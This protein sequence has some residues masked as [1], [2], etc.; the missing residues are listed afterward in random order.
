MGMGMGEN[1]MDPTALEQMANEFK[2]PEMKDFN[3]KC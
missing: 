2:S 1:G 3:E